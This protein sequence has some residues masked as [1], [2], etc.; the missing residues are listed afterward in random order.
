MLSNGKEKDVCTKKKVKF[1]QIKSNQN[2]KEINI[3]KCD[4]II[5]F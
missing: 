2:P 3:L 1:N 4:L 5:A